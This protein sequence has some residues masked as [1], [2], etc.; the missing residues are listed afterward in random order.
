MLWFLLG[1]VSDILEEEW[2][3]PGEITGTV[4]YG[5]DGEEL[6][7]T[8]AFDGT[9][10]LA[11]APQS[12]R[13]LLGGEE[14]YRDHPGRGQFLWFDEDAP[15]LGVPGLG[16]VDLNT[17]DLAFA[18]V[19]GTVFAGGDGLWVYATASEVHTSRG[20]SYALP[21][22]R[23]LA[24]EGSRILALAC[25]EDCGAW[26]LEG[27]PRWLG[28]AGGS[29]ALAFWGGEAWWSDPQE[30]DGGQGVVYSEGGDILE[31]LEGDHLGRSLG[32]GYASGTMNW[33]TAPRR[34][35]L[36]S[37]EGEATL[38]IVHS[39]GARPA[40]LAGDTHTLVVGIPGWTKAGQK[41]GATW[42][43]ERAAIP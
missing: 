12:G 25:G 2:T 31:G 21:G 32:G 37:L 20:D 1:C 43:V 11:G 36:L 13:V 23:R 14:I 34:I 15:F 7:G 22:V 33:R 28:E 17:G 38:A 40:L 39:A 9:H 26:E 24:V 8:V 30:E 6:G 19:D 3:L 41:A 35:R 5:E 10:W 27:A 18:L 16:I 29:G 42:V 4:T